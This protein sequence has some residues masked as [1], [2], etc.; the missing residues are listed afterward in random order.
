MVKTTELS[1]NVVTHER[2]KGADRLGPNGKGAGR[3]VPE[4]R[5]VDEASPA[6]R[7]NLTHPVK[8]TEQSKPVHLP[9][10][11]RKDKGGESEPQGWPTGVRVGEPEKANARL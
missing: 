2:A 8:R 5:L 4:S 6:N 11:I 9:A 10:R 1:I 3:R 7:Q